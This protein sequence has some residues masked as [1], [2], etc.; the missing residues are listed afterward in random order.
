M[1]PSVS[2]FIEFIEERSGTVS[3]C[4]KEKGDV[5]VSDFL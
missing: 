2:L 3:L 5:D 4:R 1:S